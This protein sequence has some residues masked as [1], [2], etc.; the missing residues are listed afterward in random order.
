M[1]TQM[2]NEVESGALIIIFCETSQ[3]IFLSNMAHCNAKA[4]TTI[5]YYFKIKGSSMKMLY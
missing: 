3:T 2:G 1:Y 4:G 5:L